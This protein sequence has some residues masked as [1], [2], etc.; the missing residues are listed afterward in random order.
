MHIWWDKFHECT[1]LPY[2]SKILVSFRFFSFI[3][4]H[5]C[6][7][8]QFRKDTYSFGRK[9]RIVRVEWDDVTKIPGLIQLLERNCSQYK[10]ILFLYQCFKK[11]KQT[12]KENKFAII[13]CCSAYALMTSLVS[14][15]NWRWN[16]LL[17]GGFLVFYKVFIFGSTSLWFEL[18]CKL[19][20]TCYTVVI[21][22]HKLPWNSLLCNFS[23]TAITWP[24]AT[25]DTK[26]ASINRRLLFRAI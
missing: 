17:I 26:D 1:Y 12:L 5:E 21:N 19:H 22:C 25:T 16:S 3:T 7:S 10:F 13:T 23:D 20:S 2:T 6:F 8:W 11:S 14:R 18:F 24:H 4:T 9:T 15:W